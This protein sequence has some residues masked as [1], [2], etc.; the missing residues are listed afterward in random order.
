MTQPPTE[1]N[2]Y[3]QFMSAE[4]GI[5]QLQQN[6]GDL[7]RRAEAG[8]RLLVTVEGTPA[9]VL[10]PIKDHRWRRWDEIIDIF[11]APVDSGFAED[12]HELDDHP[13]DPWAAHAPKAQG[14]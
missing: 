12:L 11:H 10:G 5:R 2:Y 4:I 9:A 7:V 14:R 13:R 3:H 1:H 8:E 6:A